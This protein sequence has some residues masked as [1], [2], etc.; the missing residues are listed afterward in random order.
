MAIAYDIETRW[1]STATTDTTTGTRT[2]THAGSANAKGAVV[3]V[4]CTGVSA[5]VT[6]VLYGGV[7]MTLVTSGWDTVEAGRIDVYALTSGVPG[8]SQTVT[9]QGAT[10]TAKWATCATVTA[11]A[12][13]AVGSF[14][15]SGDRTN[16]SGTTAFITLA[17]VASA[18]C[19]FAGIHH[20]NAAPSTTPATGAGFNPATLLHSM[21]YGQLSAQTLRS[22]NVL[23]AGT[24]PQIGVTITSDD[25]AS[26]G[27]TLIE[28]AAVLPPRPTI[29]TQAVQQS[30]MR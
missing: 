7:A 2:F 12:N 17:G 8:G 26:A 25:W 11:A 5:V 13:T 27:L 23:A 20:G 15:E 10:A 29:I 30:Y 18:M 4:M 3:L 28:G 16:L 21:D 1:P 24:D 19:V 22:T 6:G 9:L 14:T